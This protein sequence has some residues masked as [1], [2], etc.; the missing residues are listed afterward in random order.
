MSGSSSGAADPGGIESAGRPDA[1]SRLARFG[2]SGLPLES[3]PCYLCGATAGRVLVDDPPFRVIR[4]DGCGLGY[5]SPRLRGDRIH[6]LYEAQ[7]YFASDAAEAFGYDDYERD[8]DAYLRTFRRKS[9]FITRHCPPPGRLLEIGAAGGAFMKVMEELG[10][11][12]SGTEVSPSMA[13]LARRLF[14]FQ[15][16]QCC[17]LDQA[18]FDGTSFDLIAMFDVIEHLPDPKRELA[19]CRG[20]LR[21]A[22]R[23]VLQTQNLESAAR[24]LLGRRWQHFKQ[25]EHI[26][27]FS[28]ATL[29]RLLAGAGFRLLAMTRRNAG[30]YVRVQEFADR[31][32]R[33]CGLPRLLT[34]PIRLL[35]DRYCYIN[36]LDELLAIFEPA[37]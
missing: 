9:R 1:R 5:T 35:G 13:S 16:L 11:E 32:E 26:Y 30:K 37:P 31:A 28:P 15:R 24:R 17:R 8:V 4:C 2:L 14:G 19:I 29:E 3:V 10:Y 27:H 36:P 25:L 34:A 18:R 33:V 12:V 6:E 22:G 23:L 7:A 21:P 20:L